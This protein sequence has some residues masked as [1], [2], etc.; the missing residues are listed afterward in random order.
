MN[1]KVYNE[2]KRRNFYFYHYLAWTLRDEGCDTLKIEHAKQVKA[3]CDATTGVGAG[4]ET[5]TAR[6]GDRIVIE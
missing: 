4:A 2:I 1:H 6:C 5:S 3:V